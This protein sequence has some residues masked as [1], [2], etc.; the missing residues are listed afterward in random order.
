MQP[1]LHPRSLA[2]LSEQ[3]HGLQLALRLLRPL[4]L[5]A[6]TS[7]YRCCYCLGTL[8]KQLQHQAMPQA[9][10]AAHRYAVCCCF[11]GWLPL[12]THHHQAVVLALVRLT[13]PCSP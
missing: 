7:T 3:A 13:S 5:L 1:G 10:L 12:C 4:L 11:W 8:H 9:V 6:A 2:G